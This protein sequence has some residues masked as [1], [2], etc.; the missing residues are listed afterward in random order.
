MYTWS[1]FV[2]VTKLARRESFS[3]PGILQHAKS[4]ENWNIQSGVAPILSIGVSSLNLK[5][6]KQQ[7]NYK[8]WRGN[9][10][11]QVRSYVT[12]NLLSEL[13]AHMGLYKVRPVSQLW[14]IIS[15]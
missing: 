9:E 3:F 10:S 13:Q 1:Y 11:I 2:P 12:G 6:N 8:C 14:A 7:N 4:L 15:G 5:E